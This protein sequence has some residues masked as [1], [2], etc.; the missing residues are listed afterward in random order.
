MLRKLLSEQPGRDGFEIVDKLAESDCWRRAN[1]QVHVVRFAIGFK[2]LTAPLVQG[3][4]KDFFC[5]DSHLLCETPSTI[6]CD[7]N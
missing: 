1:Q 4:L 7:D 5:S 6:L 3:G 2:Q